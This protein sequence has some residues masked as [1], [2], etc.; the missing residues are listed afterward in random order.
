G[1]ELPLVT[2]AES[3]HLP[4]EY[5]TD[6]DLHEHPEMVQDAVAILSPG[7]DE[8]YSTAMR[9]A[10]D[11]AR[12]GGTNIAFLGANAIFRKIRFE[13]SPLGADR[14]VVNYKDPYEDPIRFT[15]PSEVTANW[16]GGPDPRSEDE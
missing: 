7:H 15:D 8:Y 3:L 14:I 4:I 5:A 12:D 10:L 1:N 2:L 9:N 6:V 13:D 16:Q 11:T